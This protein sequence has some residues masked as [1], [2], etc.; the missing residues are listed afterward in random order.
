VLSGNRWLRVAGIY[1]AG[2]GQLQP[3]AEI[4]A[5]GDWVMLDALSAGGVIV[6]IRTHDQELPDLCLLPGMSISVPG[7]Q[8]IRV[9]A[10]PEQSDFVECRLIVGE[11]V[12][13]ITIGTRAPTGQPQPVTVQRRVSSP[14]ESWQSIGG[15]QAFGVGAVTPAVKTLTTWLGARF[16]GGRMACALPAYSHVAFLVGPSAAP[17]LPGGSWAPALAANAVNAAGSTGYALVG[18]AT[19]VS[20]TANI[21]DRID[22]ADDPGVYVGYPAQMGLHAVLT[23]T[24]ALTTA[25]GIFGSIRLR[26]EAE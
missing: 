12:C 18:V 6:S 22:L 7:M 3:S 10:V 26:A 20:A 4:Q 11:G 16:G 17:V 1:P 21:L 13:P 25:C 9:I 8:S 5:G 15:Q 19:N 14:S 24:A 23:A 2:S